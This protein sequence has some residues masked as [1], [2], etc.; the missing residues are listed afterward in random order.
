ME[1][2]FQGRFS[3]RKLHC[4]PSALAVLLSRWG[5]GAEQEAE[6]KS[7]TGAYAGTQISTAGRFIAMFLSL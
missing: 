6:D 5:D 1:V 2:C 4:C 7:R 3:E